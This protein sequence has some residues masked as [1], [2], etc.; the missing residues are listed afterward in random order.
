MAETRMV[1]IASIVRG[2][3][4][5]MRPSGLDEPT[6]DRYREAIMEAEGRWP[7]PPC[8]MVNGFLVDGWHRVRAAESN[9][10][11]GVHHG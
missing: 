9:T 10:D 5:Q 4:L 7:F 6:V 3:R 11:G 8:E 1:S 2:R